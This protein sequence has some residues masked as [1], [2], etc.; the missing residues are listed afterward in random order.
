[1]SKEVIID[2]QNVERDAPPVSLEVAYSGPVRDKHLEG[3]S[4]E[5][6]KIIRLMAD[7]FVKSVLKRTEK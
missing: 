2:R 4:E 5:Q 6:K 1:M 7:I 3:L